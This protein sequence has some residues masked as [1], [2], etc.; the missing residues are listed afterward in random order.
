MGFDLS[1]KGNDIIIFRFIFL[2][3]S[4]RRLH[5]RR[6]QKGTCSADIGSVWLDLLTYLK[7]SCDHCANV[8]NSVIDLAHHNRNIHENNHLLKKENP[9][10][11]AQFAAYQAKYRL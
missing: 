5:I 4:L 1:R 10:F 9:D 11:A 2:N 3:A 8:A 7:R 6:L